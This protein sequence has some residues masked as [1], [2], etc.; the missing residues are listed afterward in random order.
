MIIRAPRRLPRNDA[1]ST[2]PPSR[3]RI[4][5]TASSSRHRRHGRRRAMSI[6]RHSPPSPPKMAR[7]A[8]TR[9]RCSDRYNRRRHESARCDSTMRRISIPTSR[10]Y[11]MHRPR[12]RRSRRKEEEEAWEARPA[13]PTDTTP[14]IAASCNMG[15]RIVD[16]LAP[17]T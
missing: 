7:V 6:E 11:E 14:L 8:S 2:Y 17:S 3:R 9:V 5:R 13:S 15:Q 16:K 4:S 12:R 10:C 1:R